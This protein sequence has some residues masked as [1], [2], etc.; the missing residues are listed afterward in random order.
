MSYYKKFSTNQ[1]AAPQDELEKNMQ[2][3]DALSKNEDSL[4]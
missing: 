1:S 2:E 3:G 4:K